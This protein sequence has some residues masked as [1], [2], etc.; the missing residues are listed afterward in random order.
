MNSK[1]NDQKPKKRNYFIF[2]L[3]RLTAAIPFLVW[4]RPK[5]V[6]ES[7]AA[8][9]GLRKGPALLIANHTTLAD[10]MYLMTAVW[11]RRHHFVCIKE[12]FEKNRLSRW[13]FTQ[14]RCIPIDRE[15]FSMASLRAITDELKAGRLVSMF[16]EGHINEEKPGG[17]APFK[18]GMVLLALKSSAPIVPVFIKKPKH[19]YNRL[20]VNIGEPIDI[21]SLVGEKPALS[22]IDEAAKKL[23]EKEELLIKL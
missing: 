1:P 21:R 10:P 5:C 23:H 13:I 9:R 6:Y 19:L 15:N 2:D 4:L 18:S 14:F 22:A 8:K 16:P 17:V 12:I 7:A 3:A 20:V 11:Y